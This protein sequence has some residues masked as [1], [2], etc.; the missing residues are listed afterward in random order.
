MIFERDVAGSFIEDIFAAASGA[1][2]ATNNSWLTERMGTQVGSALVNIADDG[3]L[4]GYY[5]TDDDDA[6][7]AYLAASA[8]ATAWEAEMAPFFGNFANHVRHRR[9]AIAAEIRALDGKIAKLQQKIAEEFAELKKF[10]IALENAKK[11]AAEKVR[12]AETVL[13]D[14]IAG[15]QHRRKENE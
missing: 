14:E 3:R 1:N 4:I 13:L 15:Q 6:A 10:E 2:V 5:E 12:R 7:Q 11:R 8:V 9:E